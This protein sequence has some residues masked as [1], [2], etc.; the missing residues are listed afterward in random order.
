M[1]APHKFSR[2]LHEL[3]GDEA[4]ETM[5]EWMSQ[6]DEHFRELHADMAELRHEI[7]AKFAGVDVR[8][9][10]LREEVRVGFAKVDAQAAQRHADLLERYA[11]LTK[12][13]LGFWVAS[14]VTYIGAA[15]VLARV[16]R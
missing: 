4:A 6:T 3:F 16:L 11:D 7:S 1:P 5:V 8:F 14:L 9:A 13:M 12:W 15:V 2:K 10:E